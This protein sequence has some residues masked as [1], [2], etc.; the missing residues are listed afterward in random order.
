M[1]SDLKNGMSVKTVEGSDVKITIDSAGVMVDNAKV[2]K[3]DIKASNGVVHV[4]DAVI[5]PPVAAKAAEPLEPPQQLPG[6]QRRQLRKLKKLLSRLK[7]RL[8]RAR[9][10]SRASSQ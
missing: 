5:L 7:Q 10:A 9:Q 4:I 8:R 3:A 2:I 1:S 6:K